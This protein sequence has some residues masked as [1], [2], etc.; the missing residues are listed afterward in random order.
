[1]IAKKYNVMIKS[2]FKVLISNLFPKQIY[3]RDLQFDE[4]KIYN[5]AY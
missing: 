4:N 5:Y 2:V 3:K 1:M